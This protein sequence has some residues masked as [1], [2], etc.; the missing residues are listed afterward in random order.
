LENQF[1]EKQMKKIYTDLSLSNAKRIQTRLG[2]TAK[3]IEKRNDEET[4]HTDGSKFGA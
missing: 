2:K 4:C 3:I 1:W